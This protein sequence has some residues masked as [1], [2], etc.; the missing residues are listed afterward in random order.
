[1]SRAVA[2]ALIGA[3]GL[4][5]VPVTADNTS[6]VEIVEASE[7]PALV[8]TNRLL[9]SRIDRIA[10]ASRLWRDEME[11]VR[12]NRRQAIILTPS[13]VRVADSDGTANAFDHSVV[14]EAAPVPR[15][16]SEVDVV[17]VVINLPLIEAAHRRT[18]SLPG[19]L[20]VDLDRILIHEVYGHAVPYLT[21]GHL[22]GRCPDPLPH[23]R[24]VDACAIQRE[25]AVRRELGLGRRVEYGLDS[26]GL[27][28]ALR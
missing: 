15:A 17:L 22:A 2:W 12:R 7:W 21:A 4:L 10:A 1:M 3:L 9:R 27:A 6:R 14:A 13:E 20:Y 26:L 24:A 5:S 8:A 23:E 19:E 25:N 11:T 16:N 28:R 18:G